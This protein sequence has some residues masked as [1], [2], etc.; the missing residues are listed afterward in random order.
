MKNKYIIIIIIIAAIA[1]TAASVDSIIN[2]HKGT[3]D[4]TT[5]VEEDIALIH[6]DIPDIIESN[7]R[8]AELEAQGEDA[9]G[10]TSF[11]D[12]LIEVNK[13]RLERIPA[14]QAQEIID[15]YGLDDWFEG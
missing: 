1:I 2:N 5:T 4:T 13:K 3:I 8:I 7:E 6:E 11:R 12:I 9:S 15:Q 14:D 10:T